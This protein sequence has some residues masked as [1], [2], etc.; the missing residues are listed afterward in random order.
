MTPMGTI[1]S[2]LPFA[3]K[4][5]PMMP[6]RNSGSA[7]DLILLPRSAP[8]LLIHRALQERPRPR[9]AQIPMTALSIATFTRTGFLDSRFVFPK[10]GHRSARM[11]R[12]L[13]RS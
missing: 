4:A 7:P 3:R 1:S 12:G 2:A 13:R 11:L 8:P 10:T 6:W 5:T 9:L